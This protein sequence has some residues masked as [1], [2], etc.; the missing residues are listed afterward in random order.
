VKE[1]DRIAGALPFINE[2]KV[3]TTG[4]F[5]EM[6]LKWVVSLECWR[7]VQG[8]IDSIIL[9]SPLPIPSKTDGSSLRD[10]DFSQA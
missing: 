10:A 6:T 7:K 5:E 1:N 8:L 4:R 2:I 3:V 9:E